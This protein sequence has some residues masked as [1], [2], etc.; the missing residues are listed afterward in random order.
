MGTKFDLIFSK[1]S[2]RSGS[3]CGTRANFDLLFN[4]WCFTCRNIVGWEIILIILKL[5]I[6]VP[7]QCRMETV[8]IYY[9]CEGCYKSGGLHGMGTAIS[10]E[11]IIIISSHHLLPII[12]T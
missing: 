3:H 9:F 7:N 1:E 11:V 10:T 12:L 5:V 4:K 2:C 8:L 6:D